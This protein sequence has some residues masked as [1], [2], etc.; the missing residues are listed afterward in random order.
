[1]GIVRRQSAKHS[2]VQYIGVAVGAVS[3][4]FIY[5]LNQE[6]YGFAQFLIG[7]SLMLYPLF[8]LGLNT[9]L[10]KYYPR[11]ASTVQSGH[12]F[13]RRTIW[14]SILLFLLVAIPFIA[15]KSS[16]IKMLASS[17]FS[18]IDLLADH[19]YQ[20]LILIL[21]TILIV[22]LRGQGINY[23]RIVMP[24]ILSEFSLKIF[25]P[26]S[27]LLSLYMTVTFNLFSWWMIAYYVI[28][29]LL[30]A[31]YLFKIDALSFGQGHGKSIKDMFFSKES[32]SYSLYSSLNRM[33]SLFAFRIDAFMIT[34]ILGAA[35]N[36]L[37]YVILFIAN[38]IQIPFK[39]VNQITVSL[40]SKAWEENDVQRIE[41]LYQQSARTLTLLSMTL[42]LFLYWSLSDIL[43]LSPKADQL[44]T[45]VNLFLFLGLAKVANSLTSVNEPILNYS[46][47]YKFGLY[48]VLT[49]GVSNIFLNYILISSHGLVGA[50]MATCL[51]YVIYNGIKLIFL[52]WVYKMHPFSK[53]VVAILGLSLIAILVQY[54]VQYI[55]SPFLRVPLN[56]LV[57]LV[58]LV[59]PS[60]VFKL[61]PE[62]NGLLKVVFDKIPIFGPSLKSWITKYI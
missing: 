54:P 47:Y 27:V 36:G 37:Y 38:V 55:P 30:M 1:M 3:T 33:G 57:V 58:V 29:V 61:S 15:F 44:Q 56:G 31:A 48:F 13:F 18:E 45:G 12:T 21:T 28:V 49:L 40:I 8:N 35:S 43:L 60:I 19:Y 6:L 46:K 39:S 10:L 14:L 53:G 26:V 34:L 62:F 16:I 32:I 22:I 59:L 2:L 24:A 25:L 23:R 42:F 20:V 9:L 50:A 41:D 4:L 52:F 11:F 5:P 51:A 7:T 17:G